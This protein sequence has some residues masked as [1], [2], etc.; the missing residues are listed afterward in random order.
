MPDP[1]VDKVTL[2][3]NMR[4]RR[5]AI[6][7]RARAAAA[8][9]AATHLVELPGWTAVDH[10]AVYLPQGGEFDTAPIIALARREGKNLYLPVLA[11]GNRLEFALWQAGDAL[12]DNRLGIPEP[13]PGAPRRTPAG[14]DLVCMPL[15]AWNGCGD[16][17]GMGG[18][19]YDR[20]LEDAQ[21]LKLG[22]GFELQR[23]EALV[24]ERW[25]VRMDFMLTEAAL[26]RCAGR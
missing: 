8:R 20:T 3:S 21:C 17:L 2:R 18:G 15:V 5:T 12:L 22:L 7:D 13:G 19:F 11:P 25:D 14:L 26:H 1:V 16:R 24:P 4:S 6:D 9:C 10:M 23:C